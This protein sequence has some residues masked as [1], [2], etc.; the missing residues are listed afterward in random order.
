MPRNATILLLAVL[1]LI[2]DKVYCG[3]PYSAGGLGLI[4]PDNTGITR[5]IGGAGIA[6]GEGVNMIRDN[7]ALLGT[8]SSPS[9]SIGSLYDRIQT[10]IGGIENPIH[11]KYNLSLLKFVL[12]VWRG[13]VM[14]WGLSPYSRTD[15]TLLITSK[16][17]DIFRDEMTTSGG[18]NVSTLGL[19]ASFRKRVYFGAGLNYYFGAIEENWKRTFP[20]S[21]PGMHGTTDLLKKKYKGY[22][23]TIGILYK[24]LQQ[25][26][27]GI[28]Y[29]SQADLDLN[30]ILQPGNPLDPEVPVYPD[31]Q[32]R[33]LPS[34]FRVGISSYFSERLMATI[35]YSAEQWESAAQT[36]KEK[37]MYTDSWKIGGGLRFIPSTGINDPFLMKL[38]LSVGLRA[39]KLYYKSFPMKNNVTEKAVTFG[40]EIPVGGGLGRVYNSFEFGIRGDK[41]KNGWKETFFSYGLS[42]VGVIK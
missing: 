18:I 41:G 25:T 36:L 20:D 35:D 24:P 4:M 27:I 6:V 21:I 38:P 17:D 11:A 22:S 31:P 29:T 32:S 14:S 23:G 26:Y 7:P 33:K 42:L 12:P 1:A 8:F 39:G 10:D 9:Y 28:G 3:S 34:C 2:P 19:A 40:V 13:V 37:T 15:V 5:S 16:P 30:V